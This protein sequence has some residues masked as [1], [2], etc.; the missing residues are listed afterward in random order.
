M[1]EPGPCT[2]L[3]ASVVLYQCFILIDDSWDPGSGSVLCRRLSL[4]ENANFGKARSRDDRLEHTS[5]SCIGWDF[6]KYLLYL[7]HAWRKLV[8]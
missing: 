3:M 2:A 8:D 6:I 7:L 1:D 5:L 4:K